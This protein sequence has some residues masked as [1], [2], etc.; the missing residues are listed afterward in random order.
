MIARS[1][2]ALSCLALSLACG[3]GDD[4]TEVE[5][6]QQEQ[7]P[8]EREGPA[9]CYIGSRMMCDCEI[10]EEDCT[11]DV[12]MWVSSGCASCAR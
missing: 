12:G 8:P 11:A 3:D 10:A 7:R 1:F 4:E 6:E 2:F 9:G 5:Q